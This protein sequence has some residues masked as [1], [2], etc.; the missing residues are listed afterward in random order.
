[1]MNPARV[2]NESKREPSVKCLYDLDS[3]HLAV[4]YFNNYNVCV[5]TFLGVSIISIKFDTHYVPAVA[6]E[7]MLVGLESM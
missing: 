2:S 3:F 1:M 4:S 6:S 7:V 5:F